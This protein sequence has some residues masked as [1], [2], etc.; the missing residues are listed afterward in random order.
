[1][2]PE[3]AQQIIEIL[4]TMGVRLWWVCFFLGMIFVFKK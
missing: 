2:T 3:Q 1:M 4:N